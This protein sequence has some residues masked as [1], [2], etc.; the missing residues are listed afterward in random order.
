MYLLKGSVYRSTFLFLFVYLQTYTFLG[1]IKDYIFLD[2]K[3]KNY[4]KKKKINNIHLQTSKIDVL[5]Q[6]LGVPLL[7]IFT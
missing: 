6:R 7:I 5:I 4:V 1:H 2:I 3:K